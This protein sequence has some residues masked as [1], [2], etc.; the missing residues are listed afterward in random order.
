MRIISLIFVTIGLGGCISATLVNLP[1]KD[2]PNPYAPVNAAGT[3][4]TVMFQVGHDEHEAEMRRKD[5]LKKMYK[6][7][8]SDKYKILNEEKRPNGEVYITFKC[9]RQSQLEA[10]R[11]AEVVAYVDRI[12]AMIAHMPVGSRGG[13]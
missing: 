4:G 13:R 1:D 2:S 8:G 5:S 7:C 3:P 12:K 10:K 11:V 6:A 9:D